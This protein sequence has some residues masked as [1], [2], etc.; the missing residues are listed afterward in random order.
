M[1]ICTF[2]KKSTAGEYTKVKE[3]ENICPPSKIIYMEY[4]LKFTW[5]NVFD[6]EACCNKYL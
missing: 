4:F 1:K 3:R 6:I 5:Q 2:Q